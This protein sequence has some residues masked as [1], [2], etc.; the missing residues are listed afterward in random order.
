MKA[1]YPSR[2]VTSA[3]DNIKGGVVDRRR[4]IQSC[5]CDP[6]DEQVGLLVDDFLLTLTSLCA[7][8]SER[9]LPSPYSEKDTIA[10]KIA[11][12]LPVA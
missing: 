12:G 7:A 4:F 6:D 10:F 5:G 9:Q 1:V 3:K 8:M 2:V 11:N